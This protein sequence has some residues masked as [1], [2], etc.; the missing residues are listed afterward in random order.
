MLKQIMIRSKE[1]VDGR[2]RADIFTYLIEEVGEL[3]AE[4]NVESGYSQKKPGD[5]GV[6]GEAIDAI[7]CLVDLIRRHD[8]TITKKEIDEIVENKLLKWQ[9]KVFKTK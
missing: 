4:L 3:A 6:I 7:I 1:I 5:D 9:P 8:P 2:T